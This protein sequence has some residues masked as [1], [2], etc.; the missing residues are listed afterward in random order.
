MNLIKGNYFIFLSQHLRSTILNTFLMP[1]Q[2]ALFRDKIVCNTM[3][4]H[5]IYY[6]SGIVIFFLMVNRFGNQGFRRA[7]KLFS[8]FFYFVFGGLGNKLQFC[9]PKRRKRV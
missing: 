7:F 2:I 5:L 8:F 4:L 9:T 3:F 1:V 6:F